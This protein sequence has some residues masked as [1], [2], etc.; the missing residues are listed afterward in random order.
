MSRL[1]WLAVL[2]VVLLVVFALHIATKP[3]DIPNYAQVKS[4][5]QPSYS[6]ALDRNG[7]V[8]GEVRTNFAV[9]RM[10]WVEFSQLSPAIVESFVRSE[11]KR[12]WQHS[13]AD[14]L[15]LINA[16]IGNNNALHKRGGSTITMQ[17]VSSLSANKAQRKRRSIFEKIKQIRNARKLENSWTKQQI[18][19]SWLNRIDFRGEIQGIGAASQLF[20]TKPAN[21][22]TKIEALAMAA[23]LPAPNASLATIKR[24]ACNISGKLNE[25]VP[26][27]LTAKFI[28]EIGNNKS[29][30][31]DF[32]SAY[33]IR[34]KLAAKAGDRVQSTLDKNLQ[35]KAEQIL[36]QQLSRLSRRNVRDGAI[37]VVDNISGEILVWVGS[38]SESSKSPFV[39]GVTAKRQAGSTLKPHLY[40]LAIENKVL[41]SSSILDDSALQLESVQG[42]YAPQN[43]DH[44]YVGAVSVRYALGSSLNIPAVKALKLIG[45]EPFMQRLSEL[46]YAGLDQSADYYGFALALGSIEVSLLE[47]VQAYRTIA[48]AGELSK[49]SYIKQDKAKPNTVLSKQAAFITADMLADPN[50]RRHT[51]GRNSVLDLPFPAAVKTGTSK[52]MRDNWAIGF[53]SRYTVGVWVGNFEGDPMTGVS[54]TSGA[55]PIWN[56]VMRVLHHDAKPALMVIPAGIVANEVSFVPQIEQ[57]RSEWFLQGLQRDTIYVITEDD[58]KSSIIQPIN[59]TIIALDPDIPAANQLIRLAVRGANDNLKLMLNE[60]HVQIGML[61]HPVIGQHKL[62]IIDQDKNI[63][64]QVSFSVR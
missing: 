58:V 46:G 60:E 39:D 24:R 10:N 62:Q 59:G 42:I 61:W 54:G 19:E 20:T 31:D 18:L 49:I 44:Q 15:A 48:N 7:L 35:I 37:L 30:N 47:Q 14:Y 45:V 9:R 27:E 64:D 53:T 25:P 2:S 23:M 50:A 8:L 38:N 21:G 26:C 12:F 32:A 43:Y 11:D 36:K 3:V 5:W 40:A 34:Q 4:D 17:L 13:G 56:R 52:A 28:D 51:F 6:V 57:P 16:A 33:H 1:A 63:I 55:A 41:N 29:T 22:I